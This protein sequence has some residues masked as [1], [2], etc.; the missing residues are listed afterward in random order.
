ML[1]SLGNYLQ[2]EFV[3]HMVIVYLSF[4]EIAKLFSRVVVIFPLPPALS[5]SSCSPSLPKLGIVCLIYHTC[6]C[7]FIV[8]ICNSLMIMLL[9]IFYVFTGHSYVFFGEVS[10]LEVLEKSFLE[11][12]ILLCILLL[13]YKGSFFLPVLLSYN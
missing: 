9:S 11:F 3:G 4:L 5:E 13:N 8:L 6:G 2:V 7:V 1:L 12:Y 10:V